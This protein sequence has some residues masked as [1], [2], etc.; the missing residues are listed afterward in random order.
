MN[1]DDKKIDDKEILGS[2]ADAEM[3]EFWE[4][5]K[6]KLKTMRQLEKALEPE[7]AQ[8]VNVTLTHSVDHIGIAKILAMILALI[9]IL[10]LIFHAK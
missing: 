4:S 5:Y 7:Q 8:E 1:N 9:L 3:D 10:A 2:V 6:H